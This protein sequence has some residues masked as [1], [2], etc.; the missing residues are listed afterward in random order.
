MGTMKGATE[1][2]HQGT[3]VWSEKRG[4]LNYGEKKQEGGITVRMSEKS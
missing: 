3:D 4:N 2:H 1:E